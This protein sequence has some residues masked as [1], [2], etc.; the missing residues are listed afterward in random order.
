MSVTEKNEHQ[1]KDMA[2]PRLDA[3]GSLDAQFMQ[4]CIELGRNGLGTTAPNPMVGALLVHKGKIVGEGHTSPFGGPHAEVNAINAVKEK[5]LLKECTLYVT[6]EPCSHF[7]KTP[8]CAD[9]IVKHHIPRVVVGMPDPHH[10]VAGQGIERLKQAGC[11]VNVGVLEQACREHHRRFVTFHLKKRPYVVLKWAESADGFMAP[12]KQYRETEPQPYWI[13]NSLSRQL[14]HK[15]RSEEQAILVG[16]GTALEDNPKLDVRDWSGTSPLRIVVDRHL[17]IPRDHHLLSGHPPTLVFSAKKG[18]R[19]AKSGLTHVPLPEG[20]DAMAELLRK[21]HQ[22][23]IQ[24]V[25]VEGGAKTLQSFIEADLWD[26]ARIF[27]GPKNMDNGVPAPK[28]KG[29]CLAQKRIRH[30]L[31]TILRHD[32]EHHF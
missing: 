20:P 18:E 30:D 10:K 11:E 16:T 3:H 23:N 28:I 5:A 12:L 27:R 6:L 26:E 25:M 2:I 19:M 8:P 1:K 13:T 32:Q 21:L 24:S 15:W 17:A 4:R 29:K 7:G 14:A 31:L 22:L 9:L